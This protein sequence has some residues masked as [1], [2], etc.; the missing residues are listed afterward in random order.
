MSS[1]GTQRPRRGFIRTL[2][3]GLS[4][5]VKLYTPEQYFGDALVGHK[6]SPPATA[7]RQDMKMS[8][9]SAEAPVR[10]ID[11]GESADEGEE[12]ITMVQIVCG[13][14]EEAALRNFDL[15]IRFGPCIGLSRL[16][17]WRRAERWGLDPP[18]KVLELLE[19]MDPADE[20]Q[21]C[22]WHNRL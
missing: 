20:L 3:T 22:L 6:R 9:H 13:N 16:Q 5:D 14:E 19:L 7:V 21:Q 8:R 18:A 15:E 4:E 10:L 1:R 2:G 11:F 12:G 17:R